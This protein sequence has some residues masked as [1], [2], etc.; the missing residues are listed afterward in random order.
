MKFPLALYLYLFIQ[1]IAVSFID[2]KYRK[3]SNYWSLLNIFLFFI[4]IFAFPAYFKFSFSTFFYPLAFLGVGFLLFVLK[5]MGG[6]DSKYLFSFFL[7]IPE[8]FHEPFMLKLF[9]STIVIGFSLLIY[10][11][12]RNFDK[13][14]LSIRIM[15]VRGIKS[16]YGTKFA[17]APVIAVS[18]IV[19]G[20]ELRNKFTF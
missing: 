12:I 7:L 9:Y 15:D 4:L 10:N 5:I 20:W 18:W 17:Y 14:Y 1:L 6:G 3:I 2:I 8:I 13:I 11:T 16:A 19:F